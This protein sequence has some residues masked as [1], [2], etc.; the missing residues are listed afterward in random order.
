MPAGR[1]SDYATE[2]C[3]ALVAFM[4]KGYSLTAFAGSIGVC[5]DTLNEWGRKHPEFSDAVK[6]GQAARTM[7]LETTLLAGETGPKVTGHMFALK[8]A[9]PEE[10]KD[11]VAHVGGGEGD[12]P[13]R[14]E[15][16]VKFV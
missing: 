12:D 1:P 11:K 5:R 8:N 13:I 10:W 9:A 15:L 6:R 7:C 3:E 14:Q 2:H 4:G 16:T